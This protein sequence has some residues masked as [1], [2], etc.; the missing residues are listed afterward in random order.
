MAK[1]S[2]LTAAK[3]AKND[4]FYTQISDIEKELIHYWDKLKGKIVF[5]NCDDPAE[6]NFWR[7]FHLNFERIGLKKLIAT[8]YDPEKPTYK[9][10]YEGGDDSDWSKGVLTPLKGNG[11]FRSPECVE[12]L[13][14]CDVVVTNPPF[15]LFREYVAQ[16]VQ[17]GKKFLIIGNKMSVQYKEIFPL[18]KENKLWIGYRN[19]NSDFWLKV[20]AG[21][22]FEKKIDIEGQKD[23]PVKHIMACWYT[24]IDCAKRHV[25]IPLFRRYLDDPSVYP[26]Y[27]NYDAINVDRVPDIP[28][29]YY[30]I[31]GVPITFLDKYCPQQFE[32]IGLAPERLPENES[33]LQL[34]R[35]VDAIQHKK[36]G[37]SC[38]GNKVNDGPVLV[39]GDRPGKYPFYTSPTVPGKYLEVLYSRILIRRI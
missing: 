16:L 28:E 39:H 30:D 36:D 23:V 15:S 29:D 20:P 27:D 35:Y 34:K 2:N 5:C 10:E 14:E 25:Q 33:C 17:Y 6:S 8:H 9:L 32:I 38:G 18:I 22:P 21:R 7:Y 13:Q 26:K 3:K 4:E 31:I 11:D 37:A 19:M 24:N 1:N 12:L